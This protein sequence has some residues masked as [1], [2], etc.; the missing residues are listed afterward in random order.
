M[1]APLLLGIPLWAWITGGGVGLAAGGAGIGAARMGQEAG[2]GIGE[3]FEKAIP[4]A[5][6]CL[7]VYVAFNALKK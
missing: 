4:L 1:A 3:G 6:G 5:V 2:E 7:A